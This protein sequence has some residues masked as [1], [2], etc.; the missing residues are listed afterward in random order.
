M[1]SVP[2][3]RTCSITPL[4]ITYSP[5]PVPIQNFPSESARSAPTTPLNHSPLVVNTLMKRSFFIL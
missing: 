2:V 1:L 3:S 4:F 5:L